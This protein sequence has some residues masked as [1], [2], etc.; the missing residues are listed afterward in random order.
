[1]MEENPPLPEDMVEEVLEEPL[2]TKKVKVVA[3]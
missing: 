2:P 3:E 1:M